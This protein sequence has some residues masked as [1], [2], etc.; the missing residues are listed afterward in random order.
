MKK[1]FYILLFSVYL[2]AEQ[3]IY[4]F[5]FTFNERGLF[6]NEIM[7]IKYD[8][9]TV[10]KGIILMDSEDNYV[11]ISDTFFSLP[12]FVCRP[13]QSIDDLSYYQ[14]NAKQINMCQNL[15]NM[16]GIK[17]K[18]LKI[19]NFTIFIYSNNSESNI[20]IFDNNDLAAKISTNMKLNEFM[21]I[22]HSIQKNPNYKNDIDYYIN[23]ARYFRNK[24]KINIA[25]RYL[26]S[27]FFIDETNEGLSQLQKELQDL[28]S[29]QI[30][31][32][33]EA[34]KK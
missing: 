23:K 29:K 30:V 7:L 5:S 15:F 17:S 21:S 20:F 25:M 24:G 27:A 10:S 6:T 26:F 33:Y 12:S 1:I 8:G 22:I 9:K 3:S 34:K 18:E 31:Y 14:S 28:K 2:F 11:I 16:I 4:P 32:I 19:N 13:I